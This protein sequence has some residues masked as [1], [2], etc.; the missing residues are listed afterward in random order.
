MGVDDFEIRALTKGRAQMESGTQ[1]WTV[2]E[3]VPTAFNPD[4]GATTGNGGERVLCRVDQENPQIFALHVNAALGS[5]VGSSDYQIECGLLPDFVGVG[6]GLALII[7]YGDLSGRH[8]LIA[9]CRSGVYQLPAVSFVQVSALQWSTT[10][11]A[12]GFSVSAALSRSPALNEARYFT[13]T[14]R[15]TIAAGATAEGSFG[16]RAVAIDLWSIDQ[17][18]FLTQPVIRGHFIGLLRDYLTPQFIPPWGPVLL[19][20]G[21]HQVFVSN[22][23]AAA[24]N[25]MMQVILQP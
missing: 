11:Q 2:G 8:R 3:T 13:L 15:K 20:P 14:G 24:A 25:V 21:T 6:A 22:D 17:N 23:G 9:D 19:P 10:G 1:R 18:P 7:D 16:Y 4:T 5:N 12:L